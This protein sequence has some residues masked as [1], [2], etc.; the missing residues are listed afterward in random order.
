M[1]PFYIII[2]I[3]LL[4]CGCQGT[5]PAKIDNPVVGPPPPRLP[6]EQI[7]RKKLAA[8][9][10]RRS[11]ETSVAGRTSVD[12]IDESTGLDD[13]SI[14]QVAGRRDPVQAGQ[15]PDD[16]FAETFG[17]QQVSLSNDPTVPVTKFEDGTIV[18]TV[19]GQ[20]IFAGEVLAPAVGAL[21]NKEQELRKA[22]GA[23]FKPEM[24]DR[25]RAIIIAQSLPRIVERKMLVHAA[26][27]T[28]K[29]KG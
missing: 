24:M 11:R 27:T 20:P 12:S 1:K 26:K 17:V 22:M 14:K 8:A 23:E 10:L 16:D 6:A 2:A 28:F 4:S 7:Q 21:A 25:V 13:R 5:G 15:N 9:E 19:N 3:G 29:W 18:A